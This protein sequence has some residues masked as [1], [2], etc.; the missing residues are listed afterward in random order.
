MVLILI[1]LYLF[2][3]FFHKEE[4]SGST[5][6]KSLF[7]SLLFLLF[8]LFFTGHFSF[9]DT[10]FHLK[11][12][13]LWAGALVIHLCFLSKT[14]WEQ[15]ITSLFYMFTNVIIG[16]ILSDSTAIFFCISVLYLTLNLFIFLFLW[17]SSLKTE[18]S[19]INIFEK[20]KVRIVLTKLAFLIYIL[21]SI[22]F[23][24][25]NNWI[26]PWLATFA[27]QIVALNLFLFFFDKKEDGLFNALE[28]KQT[29]FLSRLVIYGVAL[30]FFL[31][32]PAAAFLF[33][34]F[35]LSS[36]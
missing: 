30:F 8:S 32:Y 9:S 27:S 24:S 22:H 23:D 10:G 29:T 7:F 1:F 11:I 26:W 6:K 33:K 5:P 19:L 36:T 14:G 15:V 4:E 34:S 2:L 18:E 12:L 28:R 25:K 21:Y 17:V 16:R 20:G 13:F 3:F 31:L 35:F